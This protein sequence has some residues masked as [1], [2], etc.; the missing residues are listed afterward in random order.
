MNTLSLLAMLL[1]GTQSAEDSKVPWRT[2]A[3][4]TRELA[5]R[6]EKPCV[7]LYGIDGSVL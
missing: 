3:L 4:G 7:V 2:D 5:Q 1:C 6:Q